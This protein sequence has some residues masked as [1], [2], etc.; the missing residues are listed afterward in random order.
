VSR[1]TV[2][3]AARIAAIVALLLILANATLV[4]RVPPAVQAITLGRT[5]GDSHVALTH[6]TIDVD[7]SK[8][9]DRT[10]AQLHYKIVPDVPGTFTWDGSRTMIFTPAQKL[11]VA[12]KFT[13]TLSAGYRDVDGNV[14]QGPTKFAFT[15]VG[16]PVLSSSTPAAGATDVPVDTPITLTFD[17]LMDVGA[18]QSAIT[19]SPATRVQASWSGSTVTLT[20]VA[21]LAFG[22]SY[23][24]TVSDRA[25]DTDGNSP[26]A[27][28]TLAFTT[29]RAGLGLTGVVP[30]DGSAGAP[31]NGPIAI[32]FD[33]PVDPASVS[34]LIRITPPA[35]GQAQ[36]ESL[37]SDIPSATTEPTV[38]VYQPSS[39]LAPHTTYTVQLL[40][41]VKRADDPRQV[42]AGRTWSFTTGAPAGSLQNQV[43]F[44]SSRTGVRNVWAMNPDGSNPRQLT[45]ELAPVTAYDVTAD[46]Q[47][48]V[49]ASAGQVKTFA[50]GD[51]TPTVLTPAGSFDYAPRLVPDGSGVIVGRRGA[52]AGQ[53]QG[54]WLLPIDSGQQPRQLLPGGA[55]PAGS[56]GAGNDPLAAPTP[57]PWTT[58]AAVSADG[59]TALVQGTR[60]DLVRIDLASGAATAIGLHDPT[61]PIEWSDHDHGFVVDATAT[62]QS[63]SAAWVVPTT[64][65]PTHLAS[66]GDWLSVSSQGALAWLS[67]GTAQH[68]AFEPAGGGAPAVLTAAADLADR[69]AAFSPA[70]D[71]VVFVRVPASGGPSAGIWVVRI[72]GRELTQLSPDGSAPRWLP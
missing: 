54:L 18:T 36:V 41:G 47:R 66:G 60:G 48:L 30:A 31:V 3:L 25:A 5:T 7:F 56:V 58:I 67:G 21:P 38:V 68:V 70:G 26:A 53:D 39:P 35:P 15:T 14:A 51:G 37:P 62:G 24:V 72:D 46:G 71:I 23:V 42:A 20:P 16:L 49:Y 34:G 33:G 69:Q 43:L 29:V 32:L 55:P 13:V 27:P 50:I 11:P 64:G 9:V 63:A 65:P 2:E 6:S 28:I 22:T 17:R 59:A 8:A 44:L 45:D 4:D 40:D 19:V 1:R 12:T 10:S 57:D 61:G 52:I